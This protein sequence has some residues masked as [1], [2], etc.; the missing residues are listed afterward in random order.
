MGFL[1]LWQFYGG[2]KLFFASLLLHKHAYTADFVLEYFNK[3]IDIKGIMAKKGDFLE[4][5]FGLLL[6][7]Q[8]KVESYKIIIIYFVRGLICIS[9]AAC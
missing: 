8:N 4:G 9:L 3:L 6:S 5:T 1:L 2:Y 7:H